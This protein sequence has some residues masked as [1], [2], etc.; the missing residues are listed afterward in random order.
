M[1]VMNKY[2]KQIEPFVDAIAETLGKN[3]EVV[4][5]DFRYPERSIVKIANG[6]IT[7][8]TVGGPTTDLALRYL[9]G[10]KGRKDID[11][12]V[13]YRTLTSKGTELKSTTV[14]IR[15]DKGEAVGC[16][17]INIDVTPYQSAKNFIEELCRIHPYQE[18]GEIGEVPEKFD[19]DVDSLIDESFRQAMNKIGKPLAYMNKDDKLCVVRELKDKGLFLIK[20][21]AKRVS[22]ELKVSLPTIYKYLE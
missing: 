2:L 18:N 9:R 22:R 12:I 21:A 20:G 3:C 1:E 17:C 13:G 11:S 14:F 16:L 6:H 10:R 4:L 19:S 5:H 8:R 7:G 15:D